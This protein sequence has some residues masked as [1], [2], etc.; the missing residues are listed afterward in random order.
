MRKVN[1]M[2]VVTIMLGLSSFCVHAFAGKNVKPSTPGG[3][4]AIN[5]QNEQQMCL[6]MLQ[7]TIVRTGNP[8]DLAIEGEG[9]IVL[10][11]GQQDLYSRGRSIAVD[12]DY[13]LIDPST[14]YCVQRIGSAGEDD[15]F[16]SV[17]DS[18]IRIPANETLPGNATSMVKVRG[19]L[20]ANQTFSQTQVLGSNITY[21]FNGW[22]APTNVKIADLDQFSGTPS[23]G[24]IYIDII[25][26]DGT[27]VTDS[28]G[29]IV[30]WAT[31]LGDLLSYI[32]NKF[33]ADNATASLVHGEIWITDDNSGYS[34][35]DILLSYAPGGSETLVTP[36][37]FKVISVGCGHLKETTFT[38]YDSQG[39]AHLLNAA[40]VR[41]DMPDTWDLLLTSIDS[42]PSFKPGGII[43]QPT[44]GLSLPIDPNKI[45]IDPNQIHPHPI[46]IPFPIPIPK[47]PVAW[48]SNI[49][50]ITYADRRI[51]GIE[52]NGFD[53]S[54][55]GLNA[56]IG[57]I[58]EFVITF[59]HDTSNP[60]T[61]TIDL[62]TPGQFDGLTQF[63]G[64][65]TAVVKEQ[66][67]YEP[68]DLS[69]ISV[70]HNGTIVGAF[71]NNI[72]R[73]IATIQMA[74]FDNVCGL[75]SIGDG[76][77]LGSDESGEAIA[78]QAL[79]NG[80]GVIHDNA[81]EKPVE[82]TTII[83][84]SI[85]EKLEALEIIDAALEKEWTAYNVLKVMLDSG[86][87]GD[88]KK[89]DIKKAQQKVDSAIQLEKLSKKALRIS[90]K[91]LEHALRALGVEP[92]GD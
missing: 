70:K 1:L 90:I 16:Q 83:R 12:K 80:A 59:A 88:L 39:D 14:D 76:Y 3:T 46:P 77:F 23:D 47:P 92:D 11:D 72:K 6:N 25:E 86:D 52:F 49:Y 66:D 75:E 2:L 7:G 17:G 53:G 89:R 41:T 18:N 26:P 10:N 51:E 43:I 27:E 81:L 5:G 44:Q 35:T 65:S 8:L 13:Y 50:E 29:L 62:G 56:A 21:T 38:F 31:T 71:S 45:P 79:S 57:D 87:F 48:P 15:G 9:Y 30:S 60:Q 20:S 61:I 42:H 28:T 4:S 36:A 69:S 55:A 64:S 78:T 40:F 24:K 33:G 58:A 19:N 82:L 63:V 91:K 67:G 84:D 37:Y 73:D 85:D 32:D 68:G 74:M 22:F 34:R 54:Y